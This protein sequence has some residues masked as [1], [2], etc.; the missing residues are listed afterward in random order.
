MAQEKVADDGSIRRSRVM[1]LVILLRVLALFATTAATVVMALN[2]E[3]HTFAVATIGNTPVKITLTAKFQHT[4]ANIMFVIANGV[5]TLHSLLMLSVMCFVSNKYDIKGL[6][7][8]IVTALDMVTIAVLSGAATAVAFMGELARNGNS[9]A[10]WNKVCD[11]FERYCD[12][13]SGAML[14]SYI[15]ILFFMLVN[16]V[17]IFEH[18]R[19][20][21]YKN[22]IPV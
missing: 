19:F 20:N 4:P 11:N 7:F 13:G 15:G 10:R 1:M 17:N 8:I 3:S 2:K 14:A 22:P 21:P 6:R 9:H 16:L 5:A 12:Q 18:G